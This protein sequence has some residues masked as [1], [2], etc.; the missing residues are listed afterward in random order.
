MSIKNL[1]TSIVTILVLSSF[2]LTSSSHAQQSIFDTSDSSLFSN[3][4]EFLK[5]EKAFMLNF[6]QSENELDIN[7]DI[8]PG[9][10]LYKKQFKFS[11]D[12]ASYEQI[13]LPLGVEHQDEFFGVQQIYTEQ[14]S[15][16]VLLTQ[17]DK[18][19][20]FSI[21]YQ[22]CAEKGLCYPPITES[23]PLSLIS[24]LTS[25]NANDNV[26]DNGA[27]ESKNTA[28]TSIDQ[29]SEQ[30]QLVDLLQS[31]SLWVTLVAFFCWWSIVVFYPLRFPY[32]SYFNRYYCWS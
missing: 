30:H 25:D 4:N 13:V 21:T 27:E 31:G 28:A 18:D 3:E 23:I 9:Y 17:V 8:A 32:V 2:W 22:G 10:Y 26:N 19:A 20:L 14:L 29:A 24:H 12:Q 5:P 6:S 16:N 15:V 7:F 1:V 11:S